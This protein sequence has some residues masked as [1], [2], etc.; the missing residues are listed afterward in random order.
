MDKINQ[1]LYNLKNNIPQALIRINDGEAQGILE[2]GCTVA[3]GDQYVPQ[4]LSDALR[5]AL[6]HEQENYWVGLPCDKCATSKW[7]NRIKDLVRPDYEYLTKAV[8]TTNRN[9][10][11]V[12]EEFPKVLEGRRVHWVSGQDQNLSN[13]R[14]KTGIKVA[15]HIQ[16]PLKNSWSLYKQVSQWGKDFQKGSVVILSSGPLSRVLAKE[17]FQQNPEVTFLDVGSVFD[18]F[19]RNVWHSCHRGTLTKCEGCN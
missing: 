15:T 18:P 9:W 12:I 8:V 10:K 4:D 2:P 14:E 1:I 6:Q 11:L 17:W 16:T 3:R 19:T 5:E 7:Y 13:L